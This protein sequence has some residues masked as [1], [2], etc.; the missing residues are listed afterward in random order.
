VKRLS[1]ETSLGHSRGAR[2]YKDENTGAY[3]RG[4][5][6]RGKLG[7]VGRFAYL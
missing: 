2:A 1:G 6:L 4:N 3:L 7:M 5:D